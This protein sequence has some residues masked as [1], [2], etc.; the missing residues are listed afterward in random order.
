MIPFY[1][2][3]IFRNIII[4]DCAVY[5]GKLSELPVTINAIPDSGERKLYKFFGVN[6]LPKDNICEFIFNNS[7]ELYIELHEDNDKCLNEKGDLFVNDI[8]NFKITTKIIGLAPEKEL[9]YIIKF[10]PTEDIIFD[11]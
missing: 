11:G 3:I 7:G 5:W 9:E 4:K 2:M 6:L 1:I 10:G 8:D